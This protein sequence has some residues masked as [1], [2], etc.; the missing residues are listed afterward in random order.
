MDNEKIL[1]VFYSRT[2]STTQVAEALKEQ[3]KCDAEEIVDMK[4]RKGLIGFLISGFEAK[5]GRTT[6]IR[7]TKYDPSCYDR[8]IIGTPVWASNITPAIRTYIEKNRRSF[9]KVSFFCTQGGSGGEN[10]VETLK[11]LCGK[12]PDSTLIISTKEIKNKSYMT[13]I[14]SL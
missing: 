1:V 6:E 11:T 12:K 9:K 13:K 8:V 3:Y 7:Q 2:G 14:K 10:A 5:K 4:N